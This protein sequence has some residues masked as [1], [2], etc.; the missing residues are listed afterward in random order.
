MLCRN[1]YLQT[2]CKENGLCVSNLGHNHNFSTDFC[3][4]RG[5]YCTEQEMG[6][7]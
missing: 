4:H 5:G 6:E 3:Y 7:N 2:G 1:P